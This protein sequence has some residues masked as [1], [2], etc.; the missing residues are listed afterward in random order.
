ML[1]FD[2]LCGSRYQSCS[3]GCGTGASL[4][5]TGSPWGGESPLPQGRAVP[6]PPARGG[7]L[8]SRGGE[9]QGKGRRG[10]LEGPRPLDRRLPREARLRAHAR[11]GAG[12]SRGGRGGPPVFVV[13]RHD[14]RNLH[15]DLRLE[16]EGVLRSW[17]VPKG[18]S[19]DPRDKHLAV[20]TEDH[21]LEYEHFDGVIPKGE[22]GGRLDDHLGPRHV[23]HGGRARSG[24]GGRLG[25]AQAAAL[26]PAAARRVA[27]GQDQ[28][29]AE[30]LAALQVAR[31]LRGERAR[32]RARDRPRPGAPGRDA[33]ARGPGRAGAGRALL[34]AALALR[35]RVPRP[36]RAG[37]EAR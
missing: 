35:G 8:G 14:A 21:P 7:V 25:G 22:Y 26:R 4:A 6:L 2:V 18:F 30:P 34:R 27:H 16:M 12:A 23:P 11:A 36:A 20:R 15:Y 9:R 31:P 1:W 28:G 19:Y 29:R 24:Q 13:H 10:G 32:F 5:S 33:R 37:G 3:A 17:A